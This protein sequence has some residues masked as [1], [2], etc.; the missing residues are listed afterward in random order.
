M[1]KNLP[2]T[3]H[4][5]VICEANFLRLKKLMGFYAEKEYCFEVLDAENIPQK[6]LSSIGINNAQNI[7][8][9][10]FTMPIDMVLKTIF[11]Q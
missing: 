11:I 6:I 8:A 1:L 5:Q 9:E 4:H 7:S 2:K 3:A 10:H